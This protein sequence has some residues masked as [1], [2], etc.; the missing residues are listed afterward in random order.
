MENTPNRP[1]LDQGGK[2]VAG[3]TRWKSSKSSPPS[4]ELFVIANLDYNDVMKL[5][6]H[7]STAGG[8]DQAVD[9][10]VALGCNTFQ[11]FISNPRGWKITEIPDESVAA[12]RQKYD[13]NKMQDAFAHSIYLINLASPNETLRE[14]GIDSLVSGLRNV[15]RLGL[16]GLVTHIGSHQGNG[17]EI[18][19]ERV[20]EALGQILTENSGKSLLLL[21]NTAGAGNLVGKNFK[22]L[23]NIIKQSGSD[24]LGICLDTAHAFEQGYELHTAAGLD[25]MIAEIDENVGLDRL[26]AIHLNDSM[27]EL[28]S[29]RD[30][31]E[32]YGQGFIGE[33]GL[34]RIIN[35]PALRDIPFVMETPEIKDGTGTKGMIDHIR[36]LRKD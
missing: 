27:T 35:H 17:I 34:T 31:H 3:A 21:E 18:G 11:I 32:N 12:F 30:R 24:R 23:G 22:E 5:G 14:Q 13:E 10:A 29:C 36:S 16:V 26:R 33:E 15:E 8:V 28:G 1:V 25:K 6:V 7:V 19:T 2:V 9:R 20:V 4:G